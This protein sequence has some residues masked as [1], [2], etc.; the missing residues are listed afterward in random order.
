M[1]TNF[2]QERRKFGNQKFIKGKFCVQL[3]PRAAKNERRQLECSSF[4]KR[5][6]EHTLKVSQYWKRLIK[7]FFLFDRVNIPGYVYIPFADI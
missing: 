2:Q 3:F 7:Q 5:T 4:F 1:G 6:D